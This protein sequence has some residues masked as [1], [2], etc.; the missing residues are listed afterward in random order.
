MPFFIN[1]R[2][3]T[4]KNLKDYNVPAS[5]KMCGCIA[6]DIL[7]PFYSEFGGGDAKRKRV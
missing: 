6:T 4:F 2:R 5:G 3:K 1:N 7:P